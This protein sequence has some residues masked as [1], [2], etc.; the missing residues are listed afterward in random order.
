MLKG[1][2]G[3]SADGL[4]QSR[5]RAVRNAERGCGSFGGAVSGCRFV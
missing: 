1:R 5:R 3:A 4:F 2:G